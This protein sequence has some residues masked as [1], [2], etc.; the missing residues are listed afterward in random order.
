MRTGT[1]PRLIEEQ[2]TLLVPLYCKAQ[3]DN[4][5]LFDEK[6]QQILQ[7]V[8]YDFERLDIPKKTCITLCMRAK[9]MDEY[10]RDFLAD[11]P[12]GV[13]VHL[14]CG[15]DSRYL[16]T[17]NGLVEWYD[18][19]MPPVIQLRSTFYQE[20]DRYHMI[21]SSATDPAWLTEVE[22]DGKPVLVIAEGMMMYLSE[23]D[24]KALFGNLQTTFPGCHFVFDAFNTITAKRVTKHPSLRETGA[25]V[26]WGVDDP[27]IIEQWGHGIT[28]LD[29][30][31]FSQSSAINE[32]G[33]G[34]SLAF[35]VA[36]MFP[37][38]RR[39][40]R[41]LHFQLGTS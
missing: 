27:A 41:I 36:C 22:T 20:S 15:L 11:S 13:V 26:G 24:V 30:W 37:I 31:Y 3:A 19:D 21:A 32:L 38:A 23:A 2:E 40:H 28:C 34:Y 14:G 35:K 10:T 17:D 12:S 7:Q 1:K 25:N 5:I 16:R 9:R 29:E 4:S 39:A 33:W 18:L 6:A 8:N